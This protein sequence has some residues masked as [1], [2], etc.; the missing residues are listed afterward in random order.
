MEAASWQYPNLISHGSAYGACSFRDCSHICFPM[1]FL[2]TSKI[3][4]YCFSC[5][6]M[7][8]IHISVVSSSVVNKSSTCCIYLSVTHLE[9]GK[10]HVKHWNVNAPECT[11]S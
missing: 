5:I 1:G 4:A 7:V 10:M 9:H 2:K 8:L 11:L 3:Q 6:P